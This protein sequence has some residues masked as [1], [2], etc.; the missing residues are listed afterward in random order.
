MGVIAVS[1][2]HSL[3][4][5]GRLSP[6]H[7]TYAECCQSAVEGQE[8]PASPEYTRLLVHSTGIPLQQ[9]TCKFCTT[10]IYTRWHQHVCHYTERAQAGRFPLSIKTAFSSLHRI[11]F[12]LFYFVNIKSKYSLRICIVCGLHC[13]N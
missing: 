11:I 9:I 1:P 4:I 13:R 2:A 3:L 7:C 6:Y 12:Y 8:D 5:G 10:R